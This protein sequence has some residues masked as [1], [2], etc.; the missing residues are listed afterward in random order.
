M[1]IPYVWLLAG[2]VFVAAEALGISGI[3]LLFAGLGAV[4]TGSAL[5]FGF[6]AAESTD[7]QFTVF[8]LAAALFAIAL[9]KP[10]KKL[11][12]GHHPGFSDIIGAVGYV[13]SQGLTKKSGEVTWSGTIMKAQLIPDASIEHL[14]AGAQVTVVAVKGATLI[15]K[16]KD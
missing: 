7:I 12:A 10:L 3:G 2:V 15:V 13:G 11:R 4:V 6:I 5:Y 9:W 14:E 8:F 16:P 1:P